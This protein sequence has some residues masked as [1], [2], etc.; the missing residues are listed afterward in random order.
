MF[1]WYQEAKF[2]F[3]YLSDV[4]APTTEQEQGS[5]NAQ[6]ER[7]NPSRWFTRGWTLQEL[8]APLHVHFY[9]QQWVYLGSKLDLI[10]ALN[11]ITGIDLAT[12]SGTNIRSVSIARRMS[13]ASKRTT[14]RKE[15]MAYCL[16]GI[17]GVNMPLLYGEGNRAFIRLQEEIMKISEDQSLFAWEDY[18]EDGDPELFKVDDRWLRGPLAKS[19][20]EFANAADIVPYRQQNANSPSAMTSL[21]LLMNVPLHCLRNSGGKTAIYVVELTCHYEGDF[22]GSLGIYVR[23]I[24]SNQYARHRGKRGPVVIDSKLLL[25]PVQSSIYLR[26]DVMIPTAEDFDRHHGILICFHGPD[27]GFKVSYVFPSEKWKRIKGNSAIILNPGRYAAV[28]FK[29]SDE[30]QIALLMSHEQTN[31]LYGDYTWEMDK[32]RCRLFVYE[33]NIG[34][35]TAQSL[36]SIEQ[37]LKYEGARE[38]TFEADIGGCMEKTF[39][40]MRDGNRVVAE[41]TKQT[42]MGERMI[43]VDV[44]IYEPGDGLFQLSG[45]SSAK[46][47]PMTQQLGWAAQDGMP[48]QMDTAAPGT[49]IMSAAPLPAFQQSY[50]PTESMV[51]PMGQMPGAVTGSVVGQQALWMLQQG[52]QQAQQGLLLLQSASQSAIP[53]AIQPYIPAMPPAMQTYPPA[54]QTYPP[55]MQTYTPTMPPA[56]QTYTPAMPPA[57]QTY[58]PATQSYTPVDYTKY[59][60]SSKEKE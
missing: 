55:A 9:A 3:V 12:L 19:P 14:T 30:T 21:G 27:S 39:T 52:L 60:W 6:I 40:D 42:V 36:L 51:P 56:M 53:P 26:K 43:V 35:F 50:L 1:K 38:K 41:M 25:P 45:V 33:S 7:L 29:R 31:A 47:P 32:C 58:T 44:N 4:H 54:M 16:L 17:F 13:W 48:P 46:G 24:R 28:V 2:C 20:A 10:V 23:R 11:V 59:P 37:H 8:I 18:C 49:S 34:T 15:D 57:M 22:T 5:E